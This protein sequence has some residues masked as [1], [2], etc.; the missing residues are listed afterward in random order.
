MVNF[1]DAVYNGFDHLKARG[2]FVLGYVI[3]PNHLHVL[4][5]PTHGSL[6]TLVGNTKRFMAYEMVRRLEQRERYALLK[7]LEQGVPPRERKKGK[8]HQ[9]FR[10]SFDAR[11]CFDERMVEQKLDYIHH[12]PVQGKWS[13]VE[14]YVDY[15]HSSAGFYETGVQGVYEVVHYKEIDVESGAR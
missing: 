2:C 7:E 1:Y 10:L 15:R 14:D 3:L 11:L 13:L 4:L 6:N 9:V 5:Y 12:N 8:K